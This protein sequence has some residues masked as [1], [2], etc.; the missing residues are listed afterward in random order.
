MAVVNSSCVLIAR[1]PLPLAL[2]F[3]PMVGKKKHHIS[4]IYREIENKT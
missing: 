2:P 3:V 4:K 1:V